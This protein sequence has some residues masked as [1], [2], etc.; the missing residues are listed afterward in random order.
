MFFFERDL[1]RQVLNG[2][3]LYGR[4][5]DDIVISINWPHRHIL[6]QIERWNTFDVNIQLKAQIGEKVNFLD[7]YIENIN[8]HLVTKI[9]QKP[10]YKP[11]YLLFNSIHPSHIEKNILFKM[12]RCAIE[13]CSTFEVYFNE[14]EKLRMTSLLNRYP[15]HLIDKQFRRF[16]KSFILTNNYQ[17]IITVIYMNGLSTILYKKKHLLIIKEL[18]SSPMSRISP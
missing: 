12:L 14:R 15:N 10:S 7:L 9:Y 11:N 2:G 17:N 13:Y 16:S 1:V 18:F 8:G 4:Y 3:G 5:I 6:K